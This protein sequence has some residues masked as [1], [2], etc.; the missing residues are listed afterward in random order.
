ML[1]IAPPPAASAV[2]CALQSY[3]GQ[4]ECW[5]IVL[6][7]AYQMTHPKAQLTRLQMME[8]HVW[9]RGRGRGAV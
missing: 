5:E 2:S 4:P 9:R 6:G 7:H 8:G 1:G 3:S